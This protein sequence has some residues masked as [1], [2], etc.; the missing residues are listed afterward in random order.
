MFAV[1]LTAMRQRTTSYVHCTLSKRP[2]FAWDITPHQRCC[3]TVW[4]YCPSYVRT[5]IHI[6]RHRARRMDMPT[7]IANTPCPS[8]PPSLPPPP[9]SLLPTPR[10]SLPTPNSPSLSPS[11]PLPPVRPARALAPSFIRPAHPAPT[12][13]ALL[14]ASLHLHIARSL[15]A[16]VSHVRTHIALHVVPCPRLW[17]H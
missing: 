11:R 3:R 8:L 17:S 14:P 2:L 15:V 7:A 4:Q 10:P 13:C 16:V 1:R 9:P 12:S 6:G 5:C